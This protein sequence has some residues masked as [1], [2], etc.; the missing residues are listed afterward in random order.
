MLYQLQPAFS[1]EIV[2]ELINGFVT[3]DLAGMVDWKSSRDLLGRPS[4]FQVLYY[5]LPDQVTLKSWPSVNRYPA[6]LGSCMSPARRIPFVLARGI[7]AQFSGDRALV[8]TERLG[9][10]ADACAF[11]V[12][13]SDKLTFFLIQVVIL[14]WHRHLE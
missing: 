2:D 11:V 9:Y 1:L 4:L 13:L 5:I 3:Y 10:K 12:I 6:L 7:A 8:S 14:S